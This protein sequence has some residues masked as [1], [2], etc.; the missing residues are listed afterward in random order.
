MEAKA[1]ILPEYDDRQITYKQQGN[2]D[3]SWAVNYFK[4]GE[5]V[6]SEMVYK[7]PTKPDTETNEKF[8]EGCTDETLTALWG[9]LIEHLPKLP[10]EKIDQ[11]KNALK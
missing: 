3:D 7:D 9:K 1:Q 5:L 8:L 6:H 2:G 11:L 4:K 10:R